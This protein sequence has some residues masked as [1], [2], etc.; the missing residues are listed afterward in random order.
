M[1]TLA[2]S[3]TVVP[4]D[5]FAGL[6]YMLP[7]T[8]EQVFAAAGIAYKAG[9]SLDQYMA[10]KC[11][12]GEMRRKARLVEEVMQITEAKTEEEALAT[13]QTW[14]RNQAARDQGQ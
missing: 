12:L 6:D 4:D 3:N 5:P 13:L 11:A 1:L 14:I 10:A 7:A 2:V 8:R 9:D